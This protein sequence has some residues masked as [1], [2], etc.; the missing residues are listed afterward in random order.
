MI[1]KEVE[2]YLENHEEILRNFKQRSDVIIFCSLER[3]PSENVLEGGQIHLDTKL[4]S[5]GTDNNWKRRSLE[6]GFSI[7]GLG[8]WVKNSAID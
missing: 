5:R 6:C 7:S 3:W 8:I 4:V 2:F 1:R